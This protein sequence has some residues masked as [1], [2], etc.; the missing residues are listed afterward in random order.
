[1][2][3]PLEYLVVVEVREV[4]QPQNQYLVEVQA[5]NK[6]RETTPEMLVRVTCIECIFSDF[7]LFRRRHHP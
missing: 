5:R 3:P 7:S 2:I 1:M 4:V 6:T